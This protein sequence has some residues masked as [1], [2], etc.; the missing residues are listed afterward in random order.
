V[1]KLK[2]YMDMK[3]NSLTAIFSLLTALDC[4]AANWN[5]ERIN[6]DLGPL[7]CD[8]ATES[9]YYVYFCITQTVQKKCWKQLVESVGATADLWMRCT[10]FLY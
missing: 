5:K 4:A 3:L 2:P 9:L 10:V 6:P 7:N 1:L 8:C